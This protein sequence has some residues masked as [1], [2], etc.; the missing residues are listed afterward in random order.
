MLGW[1]RVFLCRLAFVWI[2]I[3]LPAAS[4]AQ[5]DSGDRRHAVVGVQV[6]GEPE[7]QRGEI[8]ELLALEIE[9]G[10][11][12]T[13]EQEWRDIV[14]ATGRYREVTIVAEPAA[15]GVR[16]TVRVERK[17]VVSEVRI[18]GHEELPL[19]QLERVARL[20]VGTV[21]E[22]Q[23]M[24]GVRQR[25][26]TLYRDEGFPDADVTVRVLPDGDATAQVRV[27]IREGHPQRVRKVEVE[28]LS[29]AEAEQVRRRSRLKTPQRWTAALRRTAE[30][31]ALSA[32]RELGYL[33]GRV[34]VE[35][36]DQGDHD[37]TVILRVR[38]G[39]RCEVIFQ[40][41]RKLSDR[42]LLGLARLDKRRLVTE[43]TWRQLER[44]IRQAYQ[45]R[46]HYLVSVR[47]VVEK[48]PPGTKRIVFTIDEGPVW[49]IRRVEFE[50]RQR[51]PAKRLREVMV[52]GPPAWFPW[53]R[54]YFV[55]E[56]F[57]EDLRRLW[58][59][60]REFGFT[61]AQITD[62]RIEL[63]RQRARIDLT[64]VVDEGLPVSIARSLVE[65]LPAGFN[66][67]KRREI[68]PGRPL[69]PAA[70]DREAE[71]LLQA[72]RDAG[73]RDATVA[74]DWVIVTR[75]S[76]RQL[77]EVRLSV[78]PGPQ[79]RIGRV[80]VRGNLQ[81]ASEL[82]ERESRLRPGMPVAARTLADA[83]NRLYQLGMFRSA[84]VED[85]NASAG[86]TP[87][88][89]VVTSDVSV[90][91]RERPPISMSYGGGYNTRDGFRIFGE[92]AH[93][94]LAHGA[95]RLSLRGDLAL[96]PA[97]AA[98]PNQYL[99]D[100]GFRDPQFFGTR[101]ALRANLIGHRATTA[102][103]QFSIERLAFVPALERRWRP[104]LLTGV[105]LQF[106]QARIFDLRPD[107]RAFNPADE[108]QLVTSSFGPF[109]VFEGRDDP[110]MPRRGVFESLR[111]RIAP[112]ALFTDEPFAK[113]QWH[114]SHYIPIGESLT[115]LYAVRGGWARTFSGAIVPIRERFFLGGRSTVRGFSENSIGPLGAP[116][117]DG[118][119]NRLFP[120][121][122]PLGGDLA[123]NI[124]TELRFPLWLGA[125]GAVFVDGG[126]VY[127][128]DRSV[129]LADFRRS[130][131]LGVLYETPVGPLA[132]HYGIKLDRRPGEA[133]GAVHFTIGTF[134]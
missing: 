47:V 128:Q 66:A 48:I 57:E 52:T 45:E 87:S 80:L 83:Q 29:G 115:F 3:C 23:T 72:L 88:T 84:E 101:W 10:W 116:I 126:A 132:L 6:L 27:D 86:T 74:A 133:F 114:H 38:A 30:S 75:T 69:D 20:P 21:V 16:V 33:E 56:Q 109:L 31:S 58:S 103:D 63:D 93:L 111:L 13:S 5:R 104:G 90:T 59:R 94:N 8:A 70:L 17:F 100:L 51:M 41:N 130:A 131:G 49:K 125:L 113:I 85:L 1:W 78:N 11:T 127:F 15:A 71:G 77:A 121:R 32:V 118:L 102:V 67:G 92:V 26:L 62:Y 99:A 19:R 107:A 50:G 55:P 7:W 14:L 122:S 117:F 36:R 22:E 96:D 89:P 60:Y 2:A 35:F 54:G 106:E 65:G 39:P 18:S 61:E 112:G 73:F 82:I 53:R 24:I 105:E 91:V 123:M 97:Q 37:G 43:G 108:G 110:F 95:E 79:Y 46:G 129:S 81:M 9:R 76:D 124:N 64:I 40:G 44:L 34:E 120:G 68:H 4:V 98:V 12:K 28:G 25:L 134:F 119:G 42:E